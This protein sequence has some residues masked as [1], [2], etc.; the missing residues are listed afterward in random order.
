M[1]RMLLARR[2]VRVVTCL[3]RRR[4]RM[5]TS[6]PQLPD[7][8]LTLFA[9]VLLTAMRT[10]LRVNLDFLWRARNQ[11]IQGTLELRRKGR[12]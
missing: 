12:L 6:I 4:G 10:R 5:S 2:D 7:S 9:N 1:T 11:F 8:S 3:I